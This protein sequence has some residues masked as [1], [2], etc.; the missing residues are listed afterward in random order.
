MI[1]LLISIAAVAL[2]VP[3]ALSVAGGDAPEELPIYIVTPAEP[4]TVEATG[5]LEADATI[6]LSFQAGGMVSA[7]YIEEGA[8]VEEGQAIAMLEN[9]RER[10]AVANAEVA[11][12]I[13]EL[14]LD[15]LLE[16]S[17][18][19]IR[20]AEARIQAARDSYGFTANQI[21]TEDIR[22]AEL[23]YQQAQSALEAAQE[24]RIFGGGDMN[25]DFDDDDDIDGGNLEGVQ[26][27]EA[28]IGEASFNAEIARLNLENLRTV[29]NPNLGAAGATIEQAEAELARVL[30]GPSEF[31]VTS[32]E[33]V[34]QAQENALRQ[35]SVNYER[36]V[37]FA[38]TSGYVT[39]FD[40]EPGQ[41]V[42][43]SEPV[44]RLVDID[45][46]LIKVEIDEIDLRQLRVGMSA[47]IEL[48]ALPGQ[49]FGGELLS[50]A[51]TGE[52]RAGV[53]I[54]EADVALNE[55]IRGLRP[56]M[57]AT[58][59]ILVEEASDALL[60]PQQFV[61]ADV[62]GQFVN[63]V[64][65]SGTINRVPVSTSSFRGGNVDVTGGIAVGDALIAVEVE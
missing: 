1:R 38:P 50:I 18:D 8:F 62:D 49:F 30:A 64:D 45:P 26:L 37:L 10:V 5:E 15:D 34:V 11:L 46:L 33:L 51:P 6:A 54:Y 41:R 65:N 16:V 28:Q 13:A 57:T 40:I 44:M 7:L 19:D 14:Q 53:V 21:T 3:V 31:A 48:D 4:V 24:A 63:R 9:E 2:A 29:N 20:L 56:G 55:D 42:G 60:V 25:V 61:G 35:A 47:D 58:A 43:R 17:D 39:A 59:T 27:L 32:A 22:Q 36:T 12:N 52:E 23:Q